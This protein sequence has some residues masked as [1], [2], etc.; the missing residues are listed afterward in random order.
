MKHCDECRLGRLNEAHIPYLQR[1]GAYVMIVPA[2][3]ALVCDVCGRV[4]YDPDFIFKVQ[5]LL[6]QAAK[7][8]DPQADNEWQRPQTGARLGQRSRVRRSV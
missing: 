7:V 6:E 3:S 8:D 2:T 5:Y 4:D 1:L